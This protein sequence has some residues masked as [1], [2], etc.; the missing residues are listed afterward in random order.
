[1]GTEA[2]AI[3]AEFILGKGYMPYSPSISA[4]H[5]IDFIAMS[6]TSQFFL[7]VKCKPRFKYIPRTGF[8]KKDYDKYMELDRPAYILFVDTE[9][10]E[11][12]GAWLSR[13]SQETPK[14]Y[15]GNEG[16]EDVITFPLSAHTHYRYLTEE[17]VESLKKNSSS[18]YY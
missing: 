18:N 14:I 9:S 4:S 10:C 16:R 11:V 13:L 5:P 7:D 12:Y 2:E 6:G 8:D 15:K 17:E 1:M 3:G